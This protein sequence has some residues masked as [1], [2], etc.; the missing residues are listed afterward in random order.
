MHIEPKPTVF[1]GIKYRSRLEA[2]WAVFLSLHPLI[3]ELKYEPFQLKDETNGHTYTPDFEVSIHGTSLYLEIKPGVVSKEA[4]E[5]I[6]SWSC[7]LDYNLVVLAGSFFEKKV[8]P[9]AH[10][11]CD[12]EHIT[13]LLQLFNSHAQLYKTANNWRFDLK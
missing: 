13:E 8:T 3:N 7:A 9:Y 5:E 2:R 4:I 1:N 10:K 6:L 11:S 12:N